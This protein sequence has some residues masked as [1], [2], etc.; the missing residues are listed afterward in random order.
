MRGQSSSST[1]TRGVIISTL[2]NL[3]VPLSSLVVAPM[4]AAGLGVEGRG[5]LAAAIAPLSLFISLATLGLPE[6]LTYFVAKNASLVRRLLRYSVWG[7]AV[8][9]TGATVMICLLADLLAGNDEN[10]AELIKIA[11]IATIPALFLSAIRGIAS[12]RQQWT[13]I[14]YEKLVSGVVRIGSISVLFFTG[15]LT[16]L[17]ATVCLA[18]TYVVG[19]FAYVPSRTNAQQIERLQGTPGTDARTLYSYGATVWF[20]SLTGIL[21]SR[22]DQVLMTPLSSTFQLGLYVVAVNISEVILIFNGAIREV[23]FSLESSASDPNRL[24]KASRVSTLL[25]CGSAVIVGLAC[26]FVVPW[27]FGEEFSASVP[28][29][30]LLLLAVAVGNPGSIAG[31]GLS[32]RGRPGL[33]STSLAIACIVNLTIL[34]LLVPEFGAV[35]AAYATIIGNLVSSNLNIY[36]LR[37]YFDVPMLHFYSISGSDVKLIWSFFVSVLR[38]LTTKRER[39]E[40]L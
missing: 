7:L 14:A 29:A 24:T 10:L 26:P 25:T 2:G 1:M 27:L 4:L 33:R 23:T 30:L 21:L 16:P 28:V 3:A 15:F 6:A 22:L 39:R 40:I 37:K 11:S 38:K 19:L 32:A 17:S 35:G 5:E 18:S 20:G 34:V 9:G 13:R 31:A 36:W 8:A 12:G